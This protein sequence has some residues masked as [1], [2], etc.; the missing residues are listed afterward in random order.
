MRTRPRE[1]NLPA[2]EAPNPRSQVE[3]VDRWIAAFNREDLPSL[4]A[5]S[6][7]EIELRAGTKV[8]RGHE[9]LARAFPESVT[10]TITPLR[11]IAKGLRIVTPARVQY[12]W[13]ST[14]ELAGEMDEV[15]AF[16]VDSDL[17]TSMR[18]YADLD[19]AMR[20]AAAARAAL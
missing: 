3:L 13:R 18:K 10:L 5:L 4:L 9:A 7:S 16:A 19:E 17:I 11:F 6:H 14:G 20:D 1:A 2:I 12:R 15:A 8:L